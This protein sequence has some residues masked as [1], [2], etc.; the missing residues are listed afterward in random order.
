MTTKKMC[1][2]VRPVRKEFGSER[3][4]Q[5]E[6]DARTMFNVPIE[7][8]R[9]RLAKLLPS[10]GQHHAVTNLLQCHIV[11]HLIKEETEKLD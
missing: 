11:K 3:E 9:E 6:S 5:D 1:G 10:Y 4:L 2:R 7:R 8:I